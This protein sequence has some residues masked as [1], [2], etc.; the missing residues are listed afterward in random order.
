MRFGGTWAA[1]CY[2]ERLSRRLRPASTSW[3]PVLR[4]FIEF[5]PGALVGGLE[6]HV[7]QGGEDDVGR[8][9]EDFVG[10]AKAFLGKTEGNE[11]V[12]GH[13]VYDFWPLCT[14]VDAAND[15]QSMPLKKGARLAL[16]TSHAILR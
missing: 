12:F 11:Q 10:P 15:F 6:V 2:S 16:S 1:T 7:V 14:A 5:E 9:G 3:K 13:L 8:H 4:F